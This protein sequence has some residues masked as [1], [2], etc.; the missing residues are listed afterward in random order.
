LY[1]VGD[2]C[3][4]W[5]VSPDTGQVNTGGEGSADSTE[6]ESHWLHSGLDKSTGRERLRRLDAQREQITRFCADNNLDLV[7]LIPDVMSGK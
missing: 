3:S 1:L 4:L 2:K 6:L 5:S 7:A